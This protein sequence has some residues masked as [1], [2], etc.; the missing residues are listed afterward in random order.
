[1]VRIKD[2]LGSRIVQDQ[3]KVRTKNMLGPWKKLESKESL[4]F[5]V[6]IQVNI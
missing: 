2:K 3:E 4:G 6:S 1:M 5:N